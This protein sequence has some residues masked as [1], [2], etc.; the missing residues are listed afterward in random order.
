MGCELITIVSSLVFSTTE[1]AVGGP[2]KLYVN[3]RIDNVGEEAHQAFLVITHV[4]DMPYE[5]LV[6][7]E[8]IIACF[9]FFVSFF[10]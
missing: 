9:V 5:S 4:L 3:A 8:V 7:Q 1:I 2:S 10:S 6:S